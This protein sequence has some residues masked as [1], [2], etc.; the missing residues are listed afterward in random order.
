MITLLTVQVIMSS[1]MV[2]IVICGFAFLW[3]STRGVARDPFARVNAKEFEIARIAK[4]DHAPIRVAA[5][6]RNNIFVCYDY[7]EEAGTVGGGILQLTAGETGAFQKRLVAESPL[8][9]RCYGLAV[10]DGEIFVS[11][12]GINAHA[13]QGNI[14]FDNFGAVTRLLDLDG[15]GYFEFYD[16]LV[17]GLPGAR[18]PDTM[19]Q[20]NGICFDSSGDLFITTAS[21]ADRGLPDHPFDGAVLRIPMQAGSLDNLQAEVFARG[22]RNPFGIAF[23]PDSSLFV[24]DNDIDENPGDELNHVVQ[25]AHYGHPYAV[26]E[27]NSSADSGFREPILVGEDEWNFLGIAYTDSEALPPAFRHC[28]YIADFMQHAIWKM[29]LESE[30]DTY[31]ISSVEKFASV[32]S[33][34]DIAITAQGDFFVLSRNTRNLYHIH[35]RTDE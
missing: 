35:L 14:V 16:D 11:R 27:E 9:M 13:K 28:L 1:S 19:Q 8:L 33:P 32:S 25:G 4:F 22:F 31:K 2:G 3:Q 24:T 5:Q 20:N 21:A 34:I 6:D 23:G 26:A 29:R 30:G 17:T 10:R 12:S 15:D 18:G 7:F